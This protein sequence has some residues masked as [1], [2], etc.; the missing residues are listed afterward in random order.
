LHLSA[1]HSTR[2]ALIDADDA[3][4][5]FEKI[6]FALIVEH[7]NSQNE[8][9]AKGIALSAFETVS[10]QRNYQRTQAACVIPVVSQE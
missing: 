8:K 4:A 1:R 10:L 2:R 7:L 9:R 6:T 3:G 5:D